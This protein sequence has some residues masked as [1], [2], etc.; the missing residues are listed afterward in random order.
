MPPKPRP[1]PTRRLF[2]RWF[3]EY[4]PLYLSSAAL[5]L[6][7]VNL[8]SEGMVNRG[9]GHAQLGVPALAEAY[10]WALIAGAALLVRIDARRPAV[11]LALLAALY[12]CDVTLHTVSSVYLGRVGMVTGALW[13]LSFV[14][15]LVALARA[16]RIRASRAAYALASFSAVGIVVLP[17]VIRRAAPHHAELAVGGWLFLVLG[18]GATVRLRLA[19]VDALDGWGRTVLRRA[20][21]ALWGGWAGAL[22]LHVAYW[23]ADLGVSIRGAGLAGVLV[24]AATRP[25]RARAAVGLTV[26]VAIT[27]LVAPRL[28][29]PICF[30]VAAA[31]ALRAWREPQL[32][33]RATPPPAAVTAPYRRGGRLAPPPPPTTSALAPPPPPVRRAWA[34]FS[35]FA[36][37]GAVWTAGW[38]PGSDLAHLPWLDLVL[39]LVVVSACLWWRE[40]YGIVP[41][42]G[43]HFHHLFV[44]GYVPRGALEWGAALV[45]LGFALLLGSLIAQY[46]VRSTPAVPP[47]SPP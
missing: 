22:A 35:V 42:M 12:Q 10:G 46:V 27:A 7:G 40:A 30:M 38:R 25:R 19:S 24:A 3:V 26:V 37:F 14:A 43:L 9:F 44:L 39:T 36:G 33:M 47:R 20:S 1:S 4:N 31:T 6:V 13:W 15:K 29:S 23:A 11:M 28:T 8:L 32:R 41:V 45:G 21:R 16:M 5:V 17:H 2:H 34:L 18:A